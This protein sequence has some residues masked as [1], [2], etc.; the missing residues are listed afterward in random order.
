MFDA[1]H[2]SKNT[3]MSDLKEQHNNETAK[4]KKENI[5]SPKLFGARS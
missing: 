3:Q 1:Y 2:K 5:T 4:T